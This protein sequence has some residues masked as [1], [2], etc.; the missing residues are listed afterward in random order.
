MFGYS[1]GQPTFYSHFGVV[2]NTFAM[3]DVQCLANEA[4]IIACPHIEHDNRNGKEYDRICREKMLL[5][6]WKSLEL[7]P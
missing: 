5:V 7:S 2:S 6:C 3:D 1:N 4:T